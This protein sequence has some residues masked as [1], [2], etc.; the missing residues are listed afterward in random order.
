MTKK[1]NIPSLAALLYKHLSGQQEKRFTAETDGFLHVSDLFSE[2]M[3]KIFLTQREQVKITEQTPPTKRLLF[4]TGL[5]FEE[6]VKKYFNSMGIFSESYPKV[7]DNDLRIVGT[8]DGRMLNG[9]L[10]E[11]KA[12]NPALY[13]LSSRQPIR[14]HQ[15]Q[16]EEYLRMDKSKMGIIFEATW[17]EQKVPFRSHIVHFN[18]KVANVVKRTVGALREAEAGGP[19]PGRVCLSQDEKRAMQCPVR[20]L[21]FAEE[22]NKPMRT[23]EQELADG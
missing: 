11:V 6:V 22:S 5:A 8:P 20:D 3:R 21:C 14:K 1:P 4:D 23:I 2:C 7:Y 18:L 19:L 17:A 16:V 10:L 9:M 13:R 12:K 15:F